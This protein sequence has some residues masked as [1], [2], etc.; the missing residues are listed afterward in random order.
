MI[1]ATSHLCPWMPGCSY[2]VFLFI[3]QM[4]PHSLMSSLHRY[5]FFFN[6]ALTSF[7]ELTSTCPVPTEIQLPP[8]SPPW[9]P[10]VGVLPRVCSHSIVHPLHFTWLEWPA[11]CLLSL[12][13]ELLPAG[14]WPF[15]YC[16]TPSG[17]KSRTSTN[18]W[19]A[20]RKMSRG[21][22]GDENTSVRVIDRELLISVRHRE[23]L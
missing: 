18:N 10:G 8:G 12:G 19:L 23:E 4:S 5:C 9:N 7:M 22:R 1:P 11:S 20:N 14:I 2:T 6:P 3:P 15:C 13:S 16:G 21:M 17:T